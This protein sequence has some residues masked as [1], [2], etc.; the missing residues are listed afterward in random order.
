MEQKQ[1]RRQS[2]KDLANAL[3][4]RLEQWQKDG[5]TAEEAIEK[6][7]LKQY[8]FLIDYGVNLDSLILTAEQ[9]KAVDVMKK[10]PRPLFANGY[11]KKYP[12]DKQDLFQKLVECVTAN[13]AEI[14]PREKQ[15]FRDLDFTINGTAYKIVLSQPRPPKKN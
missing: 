2:K 15:N 4:A 8:D 3:L 11:T 5:C 14:A 10:S 6:L 9:Q 13:G 12:Q 7:T 1:P